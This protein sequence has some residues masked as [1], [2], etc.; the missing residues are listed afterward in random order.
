MTVAAN[1]LLQGV[2]GEAD[3]IVANILAEVIIPLI[4]QAWQL[5]PVHGL[6]CDIGYYLEKV[7]QILDAQRKR[8][9][10]IRQTQNG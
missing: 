2:T 8:G 3:I 6:L 9:F 4:P 10:K 5:L 1:N 7:D